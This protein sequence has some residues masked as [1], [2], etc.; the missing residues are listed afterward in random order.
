M[1]LIPRKTPQAPSCVPPS[2]QARPAL[3]RW[4]GHMTLPTVHGIRSGLKRSTMSASVTGSAALATGLDT[5]TAAVVWIDERGPSDAQR[6][7]CGHVSTSTVTLLESAGETYCS[8]CFAALKQLVTD[9][10]SGKIDSVGAVAKLLA[11]GYVNKAEVRRFLTQ[12]R[13]PPQPSQWS[14]AR[15]TSRRLRDGQI[16]HAVGADQQVEAGP[17]TGCVTVR[18]TR[19]DRVLVDDP[20]TWSLGKFDRDQL[21]V[22]L[23]AARSEP[24][25]AFRLDLPD[26]R[27]RLVRS[28]VDIVVADLGEERGTRL[29]VRPHPRPDRAEHCAHAPSIAFEELVAAC[30][31]AEREGLSH[32][33]I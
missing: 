22:Q 15:E 7:A 5:V 10:D 1:P 17:G 29:H 26:A 11:V 27:G 25:P 30:A 21:G 18:C 19:C 9:Y 31:A 4:R 16:S 28:A 2:S 3:S 33:R 13:Q 8:G 20:R 14:A 12:L 6:C 24:R 23:L 32:I